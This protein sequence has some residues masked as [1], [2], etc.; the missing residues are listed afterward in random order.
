MS[1]LTK[2]EQAHARE[3][4]RFLSIR[5][6]ATA[7]PK[8][9]HADPYTIRRVLDGR[10]PVSA[11]LAVRVARLAS[12]GVDDVLTGKFPPAGTCPHCGQVR[13]P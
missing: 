7:F 2:E 9:I 6:G 4:V 12:V 3:A 13:S 5:I 1:D 11:S 8:A 10:I